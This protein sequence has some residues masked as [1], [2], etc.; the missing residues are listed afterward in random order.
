MVDNELSVRDK[1]EVTQEGTRPGRTFVPD[2][3]IYE[4]PAA[5][6]LCSSA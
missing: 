2:V 1:Q 5:M 3:D 6:H 4:T